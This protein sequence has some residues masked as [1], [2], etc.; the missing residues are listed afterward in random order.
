MEAK[1]SVQI[2]QSPSMKK[3]DIWGIYQ[4]LLEGS[5]YDI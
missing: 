5:P 1:E 4:E 3:S 2:H